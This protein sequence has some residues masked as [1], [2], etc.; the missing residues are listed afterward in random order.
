VSAYRLWAD[1]QLIAKGGVVGIDTSGEIP[2][3]HIH[4]ARLPV[5]GRPFELVLQISNFHYANGGPVA[6]IEIGAEERLLAKQSLKWGI[7][8]LCSG[9]M[10]VMGAYHLV[11]F[12]FRTKNAAPLY[13]GILCLLWMVVQ[14][15]SPLNDWCANLLLGYI[16]VWFLNR[17]D[18]VC[19]IISVP[20]GY[21]FFRALYPKEFPRRIQQATWSVAAILVLLSLVLT[22]M[23]FSSAIVVYFPYTIIV[24]LYSLIRLIAVWRRQQQEV[25]FILLGFAFMTA[26]GVNDMLYDMQVIQSV[27][28]THIGMLLFISFQSFALAQLYSK[29]FAAAELLSDELADKNVALE[30]EMAERI[31]LEREVVHV[32]EEERQRISHDL[33]DGL[34]Q[35]LTSAKL[36][37]SALRRKM[38]R[39]GA[40]IPELGQLSSLLEESVNQTYDLTRG[41]WPVDH[42][43]NGN[44]PLLG[45]LIRH[46][47]ES[48]GIAIEFRQQRGCQQCSS[49]VMTQL[50]RIAQEATTNAIK[51]A[52][53]GRINVDLDCTDRRAIC[54]TVCDNG[55]G[56]SNSSRKMGGLGHKIMAHRASIIGGTLT[57]A[58]GAD[59]G[60]LVTC[61]APCEAPSTENS[62]P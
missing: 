24:M 19:L 41:L 7:A 13:F 28:M 22:T 5:V 2:N 62:K 34:C 25:L 47:S 10:L 49:T 57:I 56:R 40:R 12:C 23:T 52:R 44:A 27:F 18:M 55:I 50:F 29:S 17:F 42:A 59:G 35:L 15:I 61:T 51:H 53:T 54:L 3:Q 60:T 45:E 16:P 39:E 46:L 31:H 9:A 8:L 14:L 21:T 11:I 30:Q 36:H 58:D 1:G 38:A 4:L 37:L 43:S 20:V 48:S 32:S 33:H 26:T 6:S